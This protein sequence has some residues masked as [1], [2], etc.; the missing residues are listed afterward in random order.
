M[1]LD[2]PN[3]ER[4]TNPNKVTE[5]PIRTYSLPWSRGCLSTRDEAQIRMPSHICA[6]LR[7]RFETASQLA[8]LQVNP[9]VG[10]CEARYFYVKD[11]YFLH[12]FEC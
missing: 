10:V 2:A 8:T 4:R 5:S 9:D 11:S 12:G 6:V 3:V 7:F 1:Y